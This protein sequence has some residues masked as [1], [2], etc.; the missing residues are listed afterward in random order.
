[1]A[2][3]RQL[4]PQIRRLE[5]ARRS[6]GKPVVRYQLTVDTGIIDGR[7]KQFR[8]RYATEREA[9]EALAEVRGQL[10]QGSYVQ[11]SP[12][13]VRQA[14]DDWLAA[15]HGLKPSTVHG[16]RTSLTPVKVHLGDI[17][18]QDLT[19]RH[20]DDLV[21]AL[22]AGGGQS[23]TGKTRKPWKPRTVNYML[24]LLTAV[25]E[26]Q[27]RQGHLVRNVAALV[28]RVPSDPKPPRTL[29]AAEASKVL[30]HIRGDRYAV[31]WHLALS[32]LRRGEIAALRWSDID[33]NSGTIAVSRNRLRFGD[34]VVEGTV[35]S[36][37]SDRKLPLPDNLAATLRAAK[38]LQAADKLSIGAAY[39]SSG[40]VV[41]DEAGR[42]L[43]PHALTSR[44]S[45][46][47]IAAGVPP[48]RL[49]DARHTCGT[50]MHLEGVPI[51][52]IAAWLGHASSAFTMAT[53]VHSQEPA[54]AD[55]ARRLA[56]VVTNS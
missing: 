19:K 41:V 1:M 6:D 9:R 11:P 28:T 5:L 31:A 44:W 40:Y 2:E 23:P 46:M 37:A 49:H 50:L 51:A 7:R 17:A 27:M 22:R 36:K 20:I 42:P 45:R 24:S 3:R 33:L 15:K 39:Q 56:R 35:K 54:L 30:N 10:A 4:P 55:A 21:T 13:T 18:V 34:K 48:V 47:L 32:G 29:T 26:D 25:L 16:H 52:V 8:R 43:S 14:C 38:S 12:L 53:Y